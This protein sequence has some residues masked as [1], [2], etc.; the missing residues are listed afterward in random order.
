MGSGHFIHNTGGLNFG[1]NVREH[2]RPRSQPGATAK[3]T[4]TDRE[5]Y[6]QFSIGVRIDFAVQAD[7]LKLRRCPFHKSSP[8]DLFAFIFVSLSRSL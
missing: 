8:S 7:F 2:E 4:N 5:S 1:S 6:L 3:W